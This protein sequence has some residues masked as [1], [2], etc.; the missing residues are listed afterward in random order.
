MN[1][2]SPEQTITREELATRWG[3]VPEGIT[4]AINHGIIPD[5]ES[6]TLETIH[7][8]ES[9]HFDTNNLS[10]RLARLSAFRNEVPEEVYRAECREV[11]GVIVSEFAGTEYFPEAVQLFNEATGENQNE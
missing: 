4:Y 8:A 9:K 6:W 11:L 3:C 5:G 2:P 1:E 7:A 10:E